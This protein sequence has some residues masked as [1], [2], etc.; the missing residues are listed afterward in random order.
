MDPTPMELVGIC[1][2]ISEACSNMTI[3]TRAG[4]GARQGGHAIKQ[5]SV[6]IFFGSSV[7]CR[8][9]E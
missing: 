7:R 8:L 5:C 6:Y 3:L 9:G 2:L 1:K 4:V